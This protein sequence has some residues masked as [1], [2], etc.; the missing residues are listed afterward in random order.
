MKKDITYKYFQSLSKDKDKSVK[1][2][3]QNTLNK[4]QS[5]FIYSGLPSTIPQNILE[6]IL[7]KNG[8]CFITEF[9]GNLYALQG[10]LGGELDEY[11]KPTKYI[12]ANPY[13]NISKEYDIRT[14]G[15]LFKND[16]Y[17]C[18]L[19]DLI[20]KYAV[21]LTDCNISLNTCAVL[22]RLQMLIS[23]SDDN[24]YESANEFINKVLQGDFS[25]IAENA[26]LNGVK[27]QNVSQSG[28]V[29]ITE[30]I[31][32]MQYYKANL[33]NEIG[34]NANFNM[35][36]ER[37]NE[38]E[39]LLNNDELLPFVENM[40]QQRKLAVNAINEKYNTNITVDLKS[41]W[42][43]EKENNDKSETTLNTETETEFIENDNLSNENTETVQSIETDEKEPQT[44]ENGTKTDETDETNENENEN[45]TKIK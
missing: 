45:E 4:T 16:Y 25:I 39:I 24:T 12:V 26:F 18:G 36:R 44:A 29:K 22:T 38:T 28:N 20:G 34:L 40:L 3:I 37:L 1:F 21:L 9:D 15:I 6:E 5:M 11:Y 14:D 2:Y 41:V 30:L 19:I 32:L 31:E 33:L 10:N 17:L 13:L 43:T 8:H 7:Q 35:K 23:A 27:L 42:K